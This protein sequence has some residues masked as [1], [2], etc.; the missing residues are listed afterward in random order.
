MSVNWTSEQLDA[1]EAKG[2]AIVVSAAAGSGKTA[3]L[4][5]RIISRLTD[6]ENPVP[7]DRLLVV[8]FTNAAAAEMRERIVAS[9]TKLTE[10]NP[11]DAFLSNQLLLVK[12][13][14]ITT[15]DSF[16]IDLLR[17]NFVTAELPPDFK[18]A[19]PTENDVMRAEVLEEVLADMYD[20]EIYAESFFALLEAYTNSKANDEGFREMIDGLYL[21][22]MSLPNPEEWLMLAADAF[23][24]E[25]PFQETW[26]CK[27]LLEEVRLTL[28]KIMLE[29]EA[30]MALAA[31]DG[32]ADY[33]AF[34]QT[35]KQQYA[36]IVHEETY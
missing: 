17:K 10:A 23:G 29:Y 31:E 2:R 14:Q 12:K 15:I 30:M 8:T 5:E 34:L 16:C 36:N 33:A 7:A 35:E 32:L 3:V 4:V 21:Y 25:T 1:I 22:A 19:D 26:W 11:A 20:D 13:A 24:K 18:I 27:I 6:S 9:L 28:E